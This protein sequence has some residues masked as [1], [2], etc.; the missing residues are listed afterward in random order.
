[1]GMGEWR[2]CPTPGRGRSVRKRITDRSGFVMAIATPEVYSEI[3][4]L[5][6][7]DG[8]VQPVENIRCVEIHLVFG[9]G[10]FRV[11]I[12]GGG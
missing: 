4:G 1:M 10:R 5:Q 2:R 3:D 6:G 8:D 9:K 7:C 12:Q 11:R